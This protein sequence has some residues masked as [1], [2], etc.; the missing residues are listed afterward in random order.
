MLLKATN[1]K[2]AFFSSFDVKDFHGNFLVIILRT[3][4]SMSSLHSLLR[5]YSPQIFKEQRDV[6]HRG[7]RNK[8]KKLYNHLYICGILF[9]SMS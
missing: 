8:H 1:P 6:F 4:I 7:S 3:R 2:I 9:A 5:I